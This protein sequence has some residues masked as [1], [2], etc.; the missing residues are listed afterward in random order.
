MSFS[1]RIDLILSPIGSLPK[2]KVISKQIE[3]LGAS[4]NGPIE[5]T[6]LLSEGV[7]T[8]PKI[9]LHLLF[10]LSVSPVTNLHLLFDPSM[11]LHLPLSIAT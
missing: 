10:N 5:A 6:P 1:T 11:S 2:T 8:R 4:E 7:L 9:S 3:A